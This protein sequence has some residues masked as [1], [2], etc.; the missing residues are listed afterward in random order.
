M[1][2]GHII[3]HDELQKAVKSLAL[4]ATW[5]RVQIGLL[6]IRDYSSTEDFDHSFET[7]A[8]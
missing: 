7:K 2:P 6:K 8:S 3:S 5:Y 1:G 4:S